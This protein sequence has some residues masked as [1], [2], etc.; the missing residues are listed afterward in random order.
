MSE[1][2]EEIPLSPFWPLLIVLG[3]LLI[4]SG[5]NIYQLNLQRTFTAAQMEQMG[6][7]LNNAQAAQSRLIALMNDLIQTAS[8]DQAAAQIVNQAKAAGILRLNPNASG[9]ASSAPPPQ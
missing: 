5:F 3:A 4:W 1:E 2:Y 8:K 7:P 6:Q 9:N